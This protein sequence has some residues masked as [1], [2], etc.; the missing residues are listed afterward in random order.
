METPRRQA[1]LPVHSGDGKVQ[2]GE[3]HRPTALGD[4][5]IWPSVSVQ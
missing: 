4:P 1:E 3:A 2:G 5:G